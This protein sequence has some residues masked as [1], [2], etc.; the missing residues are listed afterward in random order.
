MKLQYLTLALALSAGVALSGCG[1]EKMT[2]PGASAQDY[3]IA[4]ARCEGEAWSQL[5]AAP[6][7]TTTVAGYYSSTGIQCT[8]NSAGGHDCKQGQRW[9]PPVYGSKDAN[10]EGRAAIVRACLI[11][12][13]WTPAS[14]G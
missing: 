1:P 2:K 11:N 8:P 10:A 3:D 4:R 12:D 13:G 6:T 7:V 5:P 9:N 14:S